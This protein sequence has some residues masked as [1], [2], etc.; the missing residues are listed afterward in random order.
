M[1][2]KEIFDKYL[3]LFKIV[4]SEAGNTTNNDVYKNVYNIFEEHNEAINSA[5]E[6]EI[7][8]N[9]FVTLCI[10]IVVYS[11]NA[12]TM[13]NDVEKANSLINDFW[14]RYIKKPTK[15]FTS[16]YGLE[17]MNE[18]DYNVLVVKREKL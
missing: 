14:I 2:T 17:T 16:K 8:F 12:E 9:L 13:S 3:I 11:I 4:V 7:P 18:L 10:S 6:R 1:T 5:I 15:S